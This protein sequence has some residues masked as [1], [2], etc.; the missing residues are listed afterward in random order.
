MGDQ[1]KQKEILRGYIDVTESGDWNL[2]LRLY[3]DFSTYG[4]SSFNQ[5][6]GSGTLLW[7]EIVYLTTPWQTAVD[8]AI[9]ELVFPYPAIGTHF[10]FSWRN[11][12][13][14]EPFTVY[15]MQ[16]YFKREAR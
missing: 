1:S 10:K 5:N 4:Y 12:N 15:P 14:G 11:A 9:H 2:T 3:T 16:T 6:L 7:S 8:K 13:A